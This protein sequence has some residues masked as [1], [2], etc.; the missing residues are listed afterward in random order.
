M[1]RQIAAEAPQYAGITY[2]RL[3]EV[4]EQVPDVGGE[5]LYY[6]GT[7]FTNRTGLGVQWPSAAE[8]GA[9]VAAATVQPTGVLTAGEGRR[10]VVPITVL[11]DAEPIMQKTALLAAR[12]PGPRAGL[13]PA[14]AAALGVQPGDTL[15]ITVGEHTITAAAYPDKSIPAGVITL[16]RRLQTQGA[17]LSAVVAPVE[18]LEKVEA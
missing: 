7:A 15:G 17:P 5:D 9:P 1:L 18:K 6:G 14:D 16:P 13:N 8:Q 4:H 11:Y 10:V 12:V 2:Q 3:A